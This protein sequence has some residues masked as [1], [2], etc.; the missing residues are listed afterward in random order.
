[1]SGRLLACLTCL[2]LASGPA[3]QQVCM[4]QALPIQQPAQSKAQPS[5][6]SPSSRRNQQ[7]SP[8]ARQPA[9]HPW[10]RSLVA[11]TA[12]SAQRARSGLSDVSDNDYASYYACLSPQSGCP[13]SS[14]QAGQALTSCSSQQLATQI[15]AQVCMRQA[16]PIQRPAQAQPKFQAHQQRRPAAQQPATETTGP[17]QPG[18]HERP[19]QSAC[20]PGLSELASGPAQP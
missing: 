1:M 9:T 3:R 10:L 19:A 18:L 17:H 16:L 12:G 6:P 8:A 7:R 14:A 2:R 4:K 13:S 11:E 20:W 15:Q 5:P